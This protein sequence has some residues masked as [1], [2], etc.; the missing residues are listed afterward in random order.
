[1]NKCGKKKGITP[2][3]ATIILLLIV[4]AIAATAWSYIM[5]YWSGLTSSNIEVVS[6]MCANK[7]TTFIGVR[8]IGTAALNTSLMTVVSTDHTITSGAWS[9]TTIT[10]YQTATWNETGCKNQMCQYQITPSGGRPM[11]ASVNCV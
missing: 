9:A 2:I 6:A 5:G 1:M 4:I 8:N 3:I 7:N 10:P 11:P